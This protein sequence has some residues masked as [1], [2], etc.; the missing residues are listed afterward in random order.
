MSQTELFRI[1]SVSIPELNEILG[2]IRKKYVIEEV[3]PENT[4]H[5]ET[6]SQQFTAEEWEAIRQEIENEL[7]A[8]FQP[9]SSALDK[10]GQ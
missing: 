7:R 9:K 4:E 1:L 8:W 10:L 3:R 6:I 5:I 2:M